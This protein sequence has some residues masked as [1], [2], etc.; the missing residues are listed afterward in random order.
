MKIKVQLLT[1]ASLLLSSL[2]NKIFASMIPAPQYQPYSQ[3]SSK[4]LPKDA[5]VYQLR[6]YLTQVTATKLQK[7]AFWHLPKT[8]AMNAL[9]GALS[10]TAASIAT[11][12]LMRKYNLNH[13]D[14]AE[15][16]PYGT[17]LLVFTVGSLVNTLVMMNKHS[18]KTV[19]LL[20]NHEREFSKLVAER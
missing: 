5:S 6:K 12:V 7:E 1:V 2:D 8:V 18:Q 19:D 4:C 14:I 10:G 9:V 17:G 20:L 13:S 3:Q 11:V 16:L 15:Y